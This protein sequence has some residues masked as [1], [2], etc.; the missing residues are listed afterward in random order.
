V[1]DFNWDIY[2][3]KF[4]SKFQVKLKEGNENMESFEYINKG[5]SNNNLKQ[6]KD[7]IL[8]LKLI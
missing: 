1:D 8:F 5:R 3:F 6:L 2:L 4:K 7:F